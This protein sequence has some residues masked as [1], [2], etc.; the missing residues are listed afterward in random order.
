MR[1]GDLTAVAAM[2]RSGIRLRAWLELG[3]GRKWRG[4]WGKQRGRIGAH[5]AQVVWAKGER[6]LR[7][8]MRTSDNLVLVRHEEASGHGCATGVGNGAAQGMGRR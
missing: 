6:T 4:R 3:E 1:S 5:D 2:A 7:E 8:I